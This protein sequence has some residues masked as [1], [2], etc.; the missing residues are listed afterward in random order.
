MARSSAAPAPTK[1]SN[2]S[3]DVKTIRCAIY[4][5]KSTEEGLQQEFN[6]LDA[7]SALLDL[8]VADI[9]CGSGH[10]LLAA[11]RSVAAFPEC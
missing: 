3:A 5:R 2:G 7:Q 10:I 11:A 4:T 1:A 6:S 9:A 8:R